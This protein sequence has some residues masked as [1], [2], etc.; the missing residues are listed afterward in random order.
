VAFEL[1]AGEILGVAGLQGSGPSA[2]LQGLF[3]CS[4]E[5]EGEATLAGTAYR[6]ASPRAAFAR[7]VALVPGDRGVSVLPAL[8]VVR[9]ATLSSVARYSPYGLLDATRERADV[10]RESKALGVR[11][12]SLDAP[13]AALSGGNQQKVALLRCLLTNPRVLLLDDPTRGVDLG[14]KAEIHGLL[15]ELAQGGM[16]ILFHTTDLEE[17][18]AVAER[19]LVFYRGRIVTT[20][21]GNELSRERLLASMMGAAT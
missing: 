17:L 7:G 14:A 9:N 16:G 11:A 5:L 4:G 15:Q 20:L 12:P 21:Q 2:L 3:G 19:A 6:P 1:G 10:A 8:S 13:A 18:V